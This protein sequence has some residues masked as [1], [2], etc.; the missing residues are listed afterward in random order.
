MRD[1]YQGSYERFWA[2]FRS[3]P[4][5]IEDSDDELLDIYCMA[6][7]YSADPDGAV[8]LPMDT[9]TGAYDHVVVVR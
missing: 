4:A 3:R 9:S 7:C 1:R 6:A 2:D 5:L 8:R